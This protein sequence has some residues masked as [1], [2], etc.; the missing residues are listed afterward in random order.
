MK[1]T[2]LLVCLRVA[3]VTVRGGLERSQLAEQCRV[4]AFERAPTGGLLVA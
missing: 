3:L 2:F 4:M 1:Q